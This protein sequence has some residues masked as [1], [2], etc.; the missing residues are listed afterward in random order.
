MKTHINE[1]FKENYT[2]QVFL[3]DVQPLSLKIKNL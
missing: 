2:I 1:Y 3:A